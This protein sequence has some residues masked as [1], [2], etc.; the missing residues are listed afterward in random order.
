MIMVCLGARLASIV[1]AFVCEYAHVGWWL[2]EVFG[3][4]FL[5]SL[6]ALA[7]I[8]IGSLFVPNVK[9]PA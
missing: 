1:R 6:A 8:V 4:L 3:Y 7:I 5:G 2:F 9:P